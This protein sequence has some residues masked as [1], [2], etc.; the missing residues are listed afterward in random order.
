MANTYIDN[1]SGYNSSVTYR[2]V[3]PAGKYLV[4]GSLYGQVTV[5]VVNQISFTLQFM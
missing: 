4:L 2:Y 1:A 3:I 5:V